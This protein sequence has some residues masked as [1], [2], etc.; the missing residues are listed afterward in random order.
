[1]EKTP[2]ETKTLSPVFQA[3]VGLLVL[4][5]IYSLAVT[6]IE[7]YERVEIHKINTESSCNKNFKWP[8][9]DIG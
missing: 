4:Y 7:A 9:P 6:G 1:M 3:V 8:Q 5:G 2:K